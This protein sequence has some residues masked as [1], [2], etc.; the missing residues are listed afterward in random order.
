MRKTKT[1]VIDIP[2][3]YGDLILIQC[4]DL[5]EV[6]KKYEL[7]GDSKG[8]EAISWKESTHKGYN[9]YFMAFRYD[10]LYHYTVAHECFHVLTNIFDDRGIEIDLIN[11]EPAAYLIGWI[12]NQCYD[13]LTFPKP[14]KN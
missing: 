2:I 5:E 10:T 11:D 9:Q 14:K 6:F 12:V 1:K 3:Y 13:F 7:N 8:F 4:E